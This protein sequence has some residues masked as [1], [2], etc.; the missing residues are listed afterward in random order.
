VDDFDDSKDAGDPAE[1]GC[2]TATPHSG[3]WLILMSLALV[4]RRRL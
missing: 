3:G 4:L 2:Q 1:C